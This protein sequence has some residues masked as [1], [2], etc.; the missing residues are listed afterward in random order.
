M[1]TSP[2]RTSLPERLAAAQRALQAASSYGALAETLVAQ[3]QV[4]TRGTSATVFERKQ[5]RWVQTTTGLTASRP[6]TL[7]LPNVDVP[8]QPVLY[9]DTSLSDDPIARIAHQLEARTAAIVPLPSWRGGHGFLGVSAD[10]AGDLTL[11]D[12][13]M[14]S[15]LALTASATG[16]T[17]H[18][19]DRPDLDDVLERHQRILEG[20]VRHEP[21]DQVLGLVCAEVESQYPGARCSVLVREPGEQVLRHAAAPSLPPAFAEA[22]DGLP[23][24]DGVGAC[25]TA[26][27]RGRP[28]VVD[29]TLTHPYTQTFLDL[30]VAHDLRAVWSYPLLDG[31]SQVLGTF[32]LYRGTTHHPDNEEL[33]GVAAVASLAGLALERARDEKSL[34]RA[35]AE[36]PLTRLPNRSAFER[37]LVAELQRTEA[38]TQPCAVL[39]LDLDGFKTVNDSLGHEAGDRVLVDVGQRLLEH[40]SAGCTIAR[41]GG[42]EFTVLVPEATPERLEQVSNEIDDALADPFTVVG[43]E[44]YLSTAIGTAVSVTGLESPHDLVRDADT[45][46]YTA[47]AAGRG[48]RVLFD[49]SLRNEVTRRVRVEAD[50][51]TALREEQLEPV[52]Q[53][54]F[55]L[56]TGTWCSVELLARWH[57]PEHGPVSPAVFVPVAEES[58]L[59]GRLGQLMLGRAARQAVAWEQVGLSMPI[60]VNVSPRQLTDPYFVA[61]V[62]GVLDAHGARPDQLALEVTESAVLADEQLAVR[63]LGQLDEA[64]VAVVIDDFGTGYS[65]IARLSDLPVRGVKVDRTFIAALGEHDRARHVV[66][67]IVD[68]AHAYG[69]VVTTEGVETPEQLALLRELGCDKAQGYVLARPM[70]AD[71]AAQLMLR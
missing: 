60:Q 6:S 25:G 43:G 15:V 49:V 42:D 16:K 65:S 47:K 37:A 19:E 34:R 55:D 20:I 8:T 4:V 68:L 57:H 61:E 45:A 70:P 17:L 41:F 1:L 52:Y 31:R 11:D 14:L 44:F 30:A 56:R 32:A 40:L 66:G 12:L 35:A 29:D 38:T 54:V 36:D 71:S 10:A 51:R 2:E 24:A 26:A 46:M 33:A 69:L 27:F 5:G 13:A 7:V 59:V 50:L 21:L 64:G 62:L 28:V 53:P 58:G 22:I 63:L 23:V 39:F 9:V 48:Q 67:A 18:E 3:A